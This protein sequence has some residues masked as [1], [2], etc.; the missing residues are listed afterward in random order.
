MNFQD[1]RVKI[2]CTVLLCVC[3]AGIFLSIMRFIEFIYQ[4]SQMGL[5]DMS[6]SIIGVV[7]IIIMDLAEVAAIMGQMVMDPGS[8]YGFREVVLA[9]E[10]QTMVVAEAVRMEVADRVAA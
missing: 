7:V 3:V 5:A 4:S 6:G 8:G 1:R 9:V 10:V 2:L